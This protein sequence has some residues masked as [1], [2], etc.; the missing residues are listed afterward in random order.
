MEQGDAAIEKGRYSEA[1]DLYSTV[2]DLAPRNYVIS[3]KALLG[4]RDAY[5]KQDLNKKAAADA[6]RE[7][8][9]G[10]GIR[11]PGWYIISAILIGNEFR[12]D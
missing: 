3:M 2:I 5:R 9:W 6:R 11:W 10:R 7:F 8:A 12:D 4:R 1:V